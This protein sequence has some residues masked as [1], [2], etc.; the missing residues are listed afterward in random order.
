MRYLRWLNLSAFLRWWG[1]G[2]LACLPVFLRR[3]LLGS[4]QRLI[5]QVLDDDFALLQE[6]QGETQEL[7]RYPLQALPEGGLRRQALKGR[8][9]PI[10]LRLPAA[11]V[12]SRTLSL[13]LAAEVNLRQVVGFEIDRLTPFAPAQV[14][15]DAYPL[16]RDPALRRLHIKFI[17]VPRGWVD[18]LLN[19]LAEAHLAPDVIDVTGVTEPINLLPP[20]RRPAKGKMAQ[21]LRWA[22]AGLALVLVTAASVLPLWRHRSIIV[23]YLLPRSV[24]AQQAAEQILL[25]RKE[26]D[27]SLESARFLLQKRQETPLT[28]DILNELTKILPDGTWIERLEINKDELHL[29]GQ[30][31]AASNL[32]GLV[33]ASKL[34]NSATFRSPVTNDSRTGKERFYLFAK[35]A[36]EP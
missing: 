31:A 28:I 23:N 24:A 33:E 27:S 16:E 30:S 9:R 25:L 26:L 21:R 32:I 14:Y 20:E 12:L 11:Q 19:R 4:P 17:A 7:G 5:L 8:N 15:Y 35:I 2:L 18:S 29:R 6:R 13:P 1:S 36:R 22:L 10:V 34:F 3:L